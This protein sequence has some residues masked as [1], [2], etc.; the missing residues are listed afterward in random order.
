L[1]I[2]DSGRGVKVVENCMLARIGFAGQ[3]VIPN[4]AGAGEA[5][6]ET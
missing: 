3:Q 6:P 5:L 2:D 4:E 1:I